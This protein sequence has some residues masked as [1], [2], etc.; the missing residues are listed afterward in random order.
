MYAE[1]NNREKNEN[2]LISNH[3]VAD[4]GGKLISESPTDVLSVIAKVIAVVLRKQN[5]PEEA[6]NSLVDQLK[7][8]KGMALFDNYVGFD[9]QEE[10]RKSREKT[11]VEQVCKKL[12]RGLTLEAIATETEE[13][14]EYIKEICEIACRPEMNY[15]VDMVFNELQDKRSFVTTQ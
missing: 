12:K 11:I 6:I 10:W 13:N 14:I 5:I 1:R 4:S 7:E 8:R 9:V 2:G 15:D 3:K